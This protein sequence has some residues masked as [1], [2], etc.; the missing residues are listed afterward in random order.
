VTGDERATGGKAPAA[1]LARM[2]VT[3]A[4]AFFA[5]ADLEEHNQQR[6]AET[7]GDQN[8]GQ[9]FARDAAD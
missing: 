7:C 4:V 8:H 3:C 2:L 5:E 9:D 1:A 6:S